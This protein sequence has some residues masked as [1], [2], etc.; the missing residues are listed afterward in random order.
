MPIPDPYKK[1][2]KKASAREKKDKKIR[3]S[4]SAVASVDHGPNQDAVSGLE[5]K[6]KGKKRDV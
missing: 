2:D 4:S 3:N 6:R 5:K 1:A